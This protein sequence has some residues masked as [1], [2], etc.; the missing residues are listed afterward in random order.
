MSGPA[1]REVKPQAAAASA[2]TSVPLDL[3]PKPMLVAEEMNA[4]TR[5]E[6]FRNLDSRCRHLRSGSVQLGR[7]GLNLGHQCMS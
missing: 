2:Y 4:T 1:K 5:V 6:H 3:D 7:H